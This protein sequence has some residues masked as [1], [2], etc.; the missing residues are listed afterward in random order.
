[1]TD[2]EERLLSPYRVLD[3]TRENGAM[4][5]KLLGDLGADVIKVEPPGGDPARNL[6]PFYH[7]NP[8]PEK[9]L[10]WFVFNV[11][12][13]S[14]TLNVET[15]DGKE[16]LKKLVRTADFLVESFPVGFLAGLGLGHDVLQQINPNI[17]TIS[18]TPFGPAGPYRDFKASDLTV[19]GQGG[20][21]HSFG[22]G[23]RAPVRISHEF[24]ASM[25]A[26]SSAAAA[27]MIALY[28]RKTT[29]E[30]QH[31]N[32]SMQEVIARV[33]TLADTDQNGIE[34]RRGGFRVQHSGSVLRT[35]LIWRCKDG[36]VMWTYGGG[37]VN[38]ERNK[39]LVRWIEE[40]GMSN[41]YLSN[42]DWENLVLDETTQDVL[43]RI[44]EPTAR[45]FLTHT[46][47]ELFQ[48]AL[49]RR[50]LLGTVS[51]VADVYRSEQLASRKYWE[52]IEHPELG[53]AI[54]YPGVITHATDDTALK[55]R[56]APFIGE[57]NAEIYQGELGLS[58]QE[59]IAL[60]QAKII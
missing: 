25:N 52:Q 33:T 41:E 10:S 24:Q 31:I 28:Q 14:I 60:K 54:S 7:D 56:R 55:R 18:I 51:T 38:V 4:C 44:A 27:A 29:G 43:D 49:K 53:T 9:S 39:A 57:H 5:G 13:K 58:G 22:D 19:W 11:N 17:I 6:G 47:E 46:K 3:M 37:P 23:D 45:F 35:T 1:M 59:M 36:D 32:I 48:G 40:E 16:L 15:A 42:F 20:K 12:K 26:G 21:M 2:T 34:P 50:I 30:G 8:D